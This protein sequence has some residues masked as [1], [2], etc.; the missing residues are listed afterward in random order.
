ME[1]TVIAPL[2]S[3]LAIFHISFAGGE[4]LDDLIGVKWPRPNVGSRIGEHH[5]VRVGV[6]A[7]RQVIHEQIASLSVESTVGARDL[8]LILQSLSQFSELVCCSLAFDASWIRKYHHNFV[9][10]EV[11]SLIKDMFKKIVAHSEFD[12]LADVMR[13]WRRPLWPVSSFCRWWPLS[14]F[15][16]VDLLSSFATRSPLL[17]RHNIKHAHHE[18]DHEQYFFHLFLIVSISK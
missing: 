14:C 3:V 8:W 12:H 10:S 17:A 11:H 15:R 18:H 1:Q 13:S 2:H 9:I 5:D 16:F 6:V 4:L 7:W